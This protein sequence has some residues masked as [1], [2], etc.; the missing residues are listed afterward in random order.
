MKAEYLADV[1]F[2][3]DIAI[4]TIEDLRVSWSI[5]RYADGLREDD[6]S[7][8]TIEHQPYT[9]VFAGMLVRLFVGMLV[10]WCVRFLCVV[11]W[12]VRL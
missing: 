9:Y 5:S 6:T 4:D 7:L 2:A 11:C 12:C 1:E 3:D 8:L 10:C